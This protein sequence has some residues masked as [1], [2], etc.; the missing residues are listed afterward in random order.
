MSNKKQ[1]SISNWF[2][3]PKPIA[4]SV[5]PTDVNS[6]EQISRDNVAVPVLQL[7]TPITNINQA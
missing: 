4:T 6:D 3:A 7:S 5:T 2:E 1:Q